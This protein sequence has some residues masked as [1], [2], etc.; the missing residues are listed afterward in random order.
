MS[1]TTSGSTPILPPPNTSPESLSR[2]RRVR[3]EA[4]WI[5]GELLG[6]IEVRSL[7]PAT[8][9][10]LDPHRLGASAGPCAPGRAREQ[11]AAPRIPNRYAGRV[12][13]GYVGWDQPPTRK[14]AKPV[15]FAPA[16][17]S[18]L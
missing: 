5:T 1:L 12:R 14:R 18:T 9:A 16:S 6:G 2:T 13:G 17:S 3:W 4:G 8:S 10:P 11:T 15:A 7:D